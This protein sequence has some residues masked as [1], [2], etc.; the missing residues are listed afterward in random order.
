MDDTISRIIALELSILQQNT[1]LKSAQKQ[2]QSCHQELRSLQKEL[3]S[4][5][6]EFSKSAPT[7]QK[8]RK[9]R[10]LS[11]KWIVILEFI[12]Q[13]RSTD[14]KEI[15]EFVKDRH[16]PISRNSLRGQICWYLQKKWVEK[17]SEHGFIS[18]TEEGA[19][20]CG[21]TPR[22]KADPPPAPLWD[23]SEEIPF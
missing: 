3:Q 1:G 9:Q 14:Y 2:L 8:S 5:K 6:A 4:L 12:G 7:V 15:M 10:P 19:K 22:Y 20:I 23:D 13:H 18:L 17:D 11:D 16:L 21:Y